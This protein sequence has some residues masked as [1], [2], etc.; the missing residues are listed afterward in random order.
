MTLNRLLAR[1]ASGGFDLEQR[2]GA[3]GLKQRPGKRF[4]NGFFS[5]GMNRYI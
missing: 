2:S 1:G 5:F 3:F 4:R